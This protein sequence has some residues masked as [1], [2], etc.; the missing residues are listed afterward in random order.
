MLG[1][2]DVHPVLAVSDLARAREFYEDTLGLMPIKTDID[3]SVMYKS[4]NSRLFLYESVF[5]GTNRA[6]AA[7]WEVEDL[8][9]VV[10]GLKGEGVTFEHYDIEGAEHDGDIHVMGEMRA[11]WF[12]DPDGNILCLGNAQ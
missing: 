11:A 5:A 8:E 7:S 6:T 12:K 10:A 3:G 1:Q 4:G 9:A 2:I